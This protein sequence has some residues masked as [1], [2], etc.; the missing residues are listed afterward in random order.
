MEA[1]ESATRRHERVPRGGRRECH[2]KAGES[3]TWRQ[4]RV[5]R[6]GRAREEVEEERQRV[7]VQVLPH[8]GEE[9]LRCSVPPC[10]V[11]VVLCMQRVL[12]VECFKCKMSLSCPYYVVLFMQSVLIM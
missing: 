12:I 9:V 5:P 1:G 2:A 10:Y 11:L 4:E 8:V 6:G 3:A 7:L